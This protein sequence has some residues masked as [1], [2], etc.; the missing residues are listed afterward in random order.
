MLRKRHND[1]FKH[2]ALNALDASGG[3]VTATAHQFG[4]SPRTLR[5]W[6]IWRDVGQHPAPPVLD[7]VAAFDT[8][9]EAMRYL[10]HKLFRQIMI[11]ADGLTEDVEHT[12]VRDR[13]IALSRLLDRFDRLQKYMPPPKRIVE[14]EFVPLPWQND[15]F[16]EDETLRHKAAMRES[17][18]WSD[19]RT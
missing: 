18:G 15:S 14:M 9:D 4:I 10:R 2:L 3:N 8:D 12:T 1:T 16:D 17:L 19:E 6:R 7:P 5:R 13:A 11:L